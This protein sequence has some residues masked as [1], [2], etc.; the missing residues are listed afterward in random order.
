M[1]EGE[2]EGKSEQRERHL[3]G[4]KGTEFHLAVVGG[5]VVPDGTLCALVTGS[6][7]VRVVVVVVEIGM[8]L[9]GVVS[10]VEECEI[11]SR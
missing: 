9:M 10:M 4:N 11:I 3:S 8:V 7:R 6:G 5:R 1:R 2:R